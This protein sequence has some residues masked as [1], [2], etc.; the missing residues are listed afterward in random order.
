MTASMLMDRLLEYEH[1]F[2]DDG[3]P[4]YYEQRVADDALFV[5]PGVGPMG[6]QAC[7]EAAG[8]APAWR[9][10]SFENVTQG[11]IEDDV[12]YVS[13]RARATRGPD[14]SPPYV[15]DMTSVWRCHDGTWQLVLHQQTPVSDG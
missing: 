14:G 5:L 10:H 7:I 4:S 15:A 2:F 9:E 8:P 3:S 12:A 6:K 1:G 11:H 13:Y